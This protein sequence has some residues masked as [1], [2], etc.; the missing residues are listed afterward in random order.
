MNAED[1]KFFLRQRFALAGGTSRLQSSEVELLKRYGAWLQALCYGQLAPTTPQQ[2]RFYEASHGRA[3]AQSQFEIAWCKYYSNIL[4]QDAMELDKARIAGKW[5]PDPSIRKPILTQINE[6]L[7]K[8]ARLGHPKAIER[9]AGPEDPDEDDS[10]ETLS[11]VRIRE[12]RAEIE[13]ERAERNRDVKGLIIDEQ[14]PREIDPIRADWSEI[15]DDRD[16]DWWE[17]LNSHAEPH[18]D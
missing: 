12:L 2:K 16:A 15:E 17:S 1:H 3:A 18:D 9:I 11:A 13:R 6:L 5:R 10:E 14:D 4:Y 8:A 7:E